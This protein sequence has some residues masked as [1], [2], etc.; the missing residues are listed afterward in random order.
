MAAHT[1]TSVDEARAL[2]ASRRLLGGSR[3]NVVVEMPQLDGGERQRWSSRLSFWLNACG[4]STG[5]VFTLAA[6]TWCVMVPLAERDALP[7]RIVA[8]VGFVL[9]AALLGKIVGLLGARVMLAIDVKRLIQRVE[10]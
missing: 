3:G 8:S 10:R 1:I 9:G 5:A 7:T 4:C 6:I 2:P